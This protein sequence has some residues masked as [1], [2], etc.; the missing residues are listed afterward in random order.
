MGAQTGDLNAVVI[1]TSKELD[2]T[3]IKVEEKPKIGDFVHSLGIN[4]LTFN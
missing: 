4:G 3:L 2:M 1:H